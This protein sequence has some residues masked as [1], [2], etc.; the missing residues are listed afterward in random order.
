MT[1]LALLEAQLAPVW[2]VFPSWRPFQGRLPELVRHGDL[3]RWEAALASLPPTR[4]SVATFDGAIVVGDAADMTEADRARLESALRGL[5]PWRKGPFELFGVKVNA[6]WRSDR[7][8]ARIA[9][10][11]ATL[12]G[13]RVLDVGCGNGYYGWRMRNAGAALVVGV[14]P[15]L[16]H[17]MQHLAAYRYLRE[18]PD[19]ACN[20]LVPCRFEHLPAGGEFDAV[21]ALGV[22][23]HQRD[24]LA[25]LRALRE[26]LRP[27]GELVVETLILEGERDIVLT[28][29]R[30]ARMRNV[31]HIPG[32]ARLCS[33][34]ADAGLHDVCVVSRTPTTPAEQRRTDWMCFDSLAE[35]L[36]PARP[37]RTVEGHPAPVR[38]VAL[39][40]R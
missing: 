22:L 3:A 40:R 5:H 33:W 35:G 39:A 27:G 20:C 24:P 26:R 1:A 4:P 2:E 15:T 11:V 16:V 7:K 14:E 17:V 29:Q 23:Y 18:T 9:P 21:F 30:Y 12:E 34:L 8:W 37:D 32:T 28:P 38:A 25:F 13:R 6:E 31:W 10:C 19:G 36:D